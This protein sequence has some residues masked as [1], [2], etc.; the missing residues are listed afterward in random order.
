MRGPN[1]RALVAIGAIVFALAVSAAAQLEVGENTSLRLNGNLQAG[2]TADYSND[3]PSDHSLSPGGNADLSGFYY[4]P[5]FLSFNTQAYYN[6]SRLNST[7]QSVFQTT[8]FA[9]SANFFGGS[10]YG[11]SIGYSKTLNSEGG[12]TVPGAGSLTTKGNTQN[13][14]AHLGP[15]SAG[16]SPGASPL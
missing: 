13:L 3:A 1:Q 5:N 9:G 4:N 16:S 7:E 12:Y 2:Y 6:Q 10:H 14:Y 11:G 8:G 15:S